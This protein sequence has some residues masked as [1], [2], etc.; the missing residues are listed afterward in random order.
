MDKRFLS[1]VLLSLVVFPSLLPATAQTPGTIQTVVGNGYQ[2]S[3][4]IGGPAA[5]AEL[6]SPNSV[7]VDKKGNVF[8]ADLASERIYKVEASTGN[9][10]VFAGT[11]AGGYSGDGGPAIEATFNH[12][13]GLAFGPAGNLFVSDSRNNVIRKIDV[14]TGIIETVAGTGFGA[15]SGDADPCGMTTPGL[16][17][18]KTVLCNPFGIAVDAGG[19][20]YFT[21]ASSQVL[22]VT[23]STAVVSVVAGD[24]NYGYSGDNGPAVSASLSWLPGLALDSQGNIYVADS[25]NCAVRKITASTGIITSV[26]GAPSSP[27]S[28][29]CGLSGDGGAASAA[30]ISGPFGLSLDAGGNI[31]VGDDVNNV[32]RMITASNGNIYTAAGSYTNGRGIYGYSGDGG[33]A[34]NATFAYPLGVTVDLAGDLYISDNQNFVVRLVTQP[35]TAIP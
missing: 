34:V 3:F 28:G 30:L 10:T 22:K 6:I 4:G 17:A 20:L 32:V 27:Y 12:P 29:T 25:G 5:A 11:G 24:G 18:K 1:L 15:G 23:A 21:N 2:G 33:P 19:N 8:I 26:V 7:A 35:A 13:F 9:I 14:S 31:F 16:K